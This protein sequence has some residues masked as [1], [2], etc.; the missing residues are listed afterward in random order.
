MIKILSDKESFL[1]KFVI[2]NKNFNFEGDLKNISFYKNSSRETASKRLEKT[3]DIINKLVSDKKNVKI[4]D[5][6]VSDGTT[7]YTLGISVW[8]RTSSTRKRVDFACSALSVCADC[9]SAGGILTICVGGARVVI[10]AFALTICYNICG[11]AV[12]IGPR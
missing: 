2:N 5:I 1:K 8:A 3:H 4:L 10:K 7:T 9:H 12:E 6:G 11:L